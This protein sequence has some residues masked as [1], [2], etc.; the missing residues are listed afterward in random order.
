MVLHDLTVERLGIRIFFLIIESIRFI[1]FSLEFSLFIG[2]YGLLG[3]TVRHVPVNRHGGPK[4]N[5]F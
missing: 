5:G 2:R 1:D 3:F 4:A